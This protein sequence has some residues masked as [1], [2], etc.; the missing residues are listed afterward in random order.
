[1]TKD[2][3]GRSTKALSFKDR[4]QKATVDGWSIQKWRFA[5]EPNQVYKTRG[6]KQSR[7]NG[8][9]SGYLLLSHLLFPPSSEN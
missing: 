3:K 5:Y 4:D 1:V 6:K 9:S 8:S 7:D 2:T